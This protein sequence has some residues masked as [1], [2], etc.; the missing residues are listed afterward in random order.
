M[1]RDQARKQHD[2]GEHEQE[3]AQDAVRQQLGRPLRL[4]PLQGHGRGFH[5]DRFLVGF[6]EGQPVGPKFSL[7]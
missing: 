1:S 4:A 7:M 2:L 6:P 3:H 5:L